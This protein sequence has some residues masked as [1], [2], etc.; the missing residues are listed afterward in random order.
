MILYAASPL[1]D[2]EIRMAEEKFAESKELAEAAMYNVLNNDVST[3]V[4]KE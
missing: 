3:D 4:L 1:L 2:D